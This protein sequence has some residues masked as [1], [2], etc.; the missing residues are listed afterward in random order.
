[1]TEDFEPTPDHRID[2]AHPGLDADPQAGGHETADPAWLDEDLE[3][4][5]RQALEANEAVEEEIGPGI[6]LSDWVEEVGGDEDEDE[7]SAPA[8]VDRSE[9]A[10]ILPPRVTSRQVIEA[11]LF[12]GGKPL[13]AKKLASLVG[14]DT[15]TGIVEEEIEG[16]NGLYSSEARPYEIRLAEGGYRLQLREEYEAVRNRVF[17][18]GPKDVKLSQEQLEV[19]ALVAYRQPISRLQIQKQG[20]KNAGGMLRQLLR[21][22][23][24]VI[25]RGNNPQRD[26]TYRTTKRFLEVFNIREI[27][28]L[29]TPEQLEL[30]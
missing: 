30:R 7:V 2:P 12:V 10:V 3:S 20:R 23:L 24:I 26:I 27:E 16:L 18:L 4:A 22:Q 8:D 19:L 28:D 1:M 15:Q 29:P 21:R 9:D 25:E 11:A 14:P 5:Y 13:T 17:G 6:E